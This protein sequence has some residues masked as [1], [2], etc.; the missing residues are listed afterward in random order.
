MNTITFGN[1]VYFGT[2]N[3]TMF[4]ETPYAGFFTLSDILC[5]SDAN[6]GTGTNNNVIDLDALRLTVNLEEG[7]S[8]TCTFVN[9]ITG[10]TAANV[11]ISGRVADEFGMAV[12]Y[13]LIQLQAGNGPGIYY[14]RTNSFGYYTL[15]DVPVGE[16]YVLTPM[17][18][19]YRFDPPSIAVQVNDTITGLDL[20]AIR[21]P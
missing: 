8:V 12:R 21:D 19:G 10:P 18:K 6:G 1:L 4:S 14:A 2:E 3:Q 11:T 7:E 9:A 5:T 15:S 20:I 13:A 16:M 17:A